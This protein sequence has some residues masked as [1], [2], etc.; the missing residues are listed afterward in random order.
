MVDAGGIS[1]GRDDDYALNLKSCQNSLCFSHLVRCVI[2][3]TTPQYVRHRQECGGK[4]DKQVDLEHLIWRAK[5]TSGQRSNKKT[6][7]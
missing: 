6:A 7:R 5:P 4:I 1:V 2:V 3:K